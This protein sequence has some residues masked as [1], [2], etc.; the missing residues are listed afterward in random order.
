MTGRRTA[1]WA[2]WAKVGSDGDRTDYGEMLSYDPEEVPDAEFH[3]AKLEDGHEL[4]VTNHVTRGEDGHPFVDHSK[5]YSWHVWDPYEPDL[6]DAGGAPSDQHLLS[7]SRRGKTH[8][9]PTLDQ[10]KEEAEAA[11]VDLARGGLKGLQGHPNNPGINR[12][13]ERRDDDGPG[14]RGRIL[15]SL[16]MVDI[17]RLAGDG[18]SWEDTMAHIDR[19]LAE[20]EPE[21]RSDYSTDY[22][23]DGHGEHDVD[24]DPYDPY[25]HRVDWDEVPPHPDQDWQQ[26]PDYDTGYVTEQH[27]KVKDGRHVLVEKDEVRG[28]WTWSHFN[29]DPFGAAS[30]PNAWGNLPTREQ[31]FRAAEDALAHTSGEAHTWSDMRHHGHDPMDQGDPLTYEGDP[32]FANIHHPNYRQYMEQRGLTP[33]TSRLDMADL[34]RLAGDGMSWEDTMRHI[35]EQLAAGFHEAARTAAGAAPVQD[36]AAMAPQAPVAGGYQPGHRVGLPWRDQVVRGTVIGVDGPEAII[37]WDDGQYSNEEPRNI[38][39]L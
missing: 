27:H 10:A 14:G 2:D 34:V 7:E 13:I 23:H 1:A 4:H 26:T 16:D 38:Q 11:Y 17:I 20:G 32:E 31:A 22:Y 6:I 24:G 21:D 5:G 18:M 36:P 33:R 28:G 37:R 8:H 19:V 25:D 12:G 15:G 3:V 35:D 30:S 39:L 9:I 29:G